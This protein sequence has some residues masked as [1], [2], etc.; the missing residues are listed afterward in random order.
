[1]RHPDHPELYVICDDCKRITIVY[2]M[3]D[4][5]EES[6]E[7][8]LDCFNNYPCLTEHEEGCAT[9]VHKG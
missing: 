3:C 1:M 7:R 9:I 6:K 4:E 2:Y 5:D 8:C